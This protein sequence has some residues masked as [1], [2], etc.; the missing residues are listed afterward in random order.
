MIS[1]MFWPFALKAMAER[2]NK[3]HISPDG[4]TPESELYGISPQDIP[5]ASYHTLFC[6]I[7]VL[8]S[9]LHNAGAIGPPKWEPRSRIG[10]CLGHSPFHAGL[11]ALVFNPATGHVSPQFHVVFDDDFSTVPYMEK[12]VIPPNWEELYQ[13]YWELVTEEDFHLADS[14]FCL[15]ADTIGGDGAS[16]PITDPFEIV[17]PGPQD[18]SDNIRTPVATSRPG[19]IRNSLVSDRDA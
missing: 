8:D 16:R 10:V 15:H 17:T 19:N 12:A 14:W 6:P 2:M 18:V 3:L 9:R 5:T 13:S 4:S 7:Y 1:T 11:I